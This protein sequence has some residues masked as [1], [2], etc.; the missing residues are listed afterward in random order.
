VRADI[1]ASEQANDLARAEHLRTEQAWL[2]DELAAATGLGGRRRQFSGATERARVSVGKA[3][4]RAIDR[5]GQCDPVIADEL[6]TGI[7]TGV[8]CEYRPSSAP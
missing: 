7:S 1:D 3:V 5:I 2:V 8:R 6:R 4:R